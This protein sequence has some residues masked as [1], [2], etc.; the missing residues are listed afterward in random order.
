M[1]LKC[2]CAAQAEGYKMLIEINIDFLV[3]GAK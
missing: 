3:L 2:G 1:A